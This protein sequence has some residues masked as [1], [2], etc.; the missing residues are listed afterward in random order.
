[1]ETQY[2][3]KRERLSKEALLEKLLPKASTRA[4]SKYFLGNK[5]ASQ[6][7][8]RR[9]NNG[10]QI[11][12]DILLELAQPLRGAT[13]SRKSEK[14]LAKLISKGIEIR[15]PRAPSDEVEEVIIKYANT[16][17]DS[18][19]IFLDEILSYRD[20][21]G[22]ITSEVISKSATLEPH[23]KVDKNYMESLTARA[24]YIRNL[25]VE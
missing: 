20:D 18:N 3:D 4:L 8:E 13:F 24:E 11:E 12:L 1:M 22:K 17:L 7:I 16:Q 2:S 25:R 9:I 5:Y 6:E 19:T 21:I 10:Q 23:L 15:T 14:H